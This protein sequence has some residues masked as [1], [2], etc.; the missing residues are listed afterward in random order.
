VEAGVRVRWDAARGQILIAIDEEPAFRVMKPTESFVTPRAM[1]ITYPRLNPLRVEAIVVTEGGPAASGTVAARLR[2]L[3]GLASV[4]TPSPIAVPDGGS[5]TSAPAPCAALAAAQGD[6]RALV[7]ALGAGRAAPT[8]ATQLAT[9]RTAIDDGFAAGGDGPAAVGMATSLMDRVLT[10]V[11]ASTTEVTRI[12]RRLESDASPP[13]AGDAC[14]ASARAVYDTLRLT[15]PRVRLAQLAAVRSAVALLRDALHRDYM[16]TG[17]N[18]WTGDAYRVGADLAPTQASRVTALIRVTH[19]AFDVEPSSGALVGAEEPSQVGVVHAQRFT[20]FAMEF[21]VGTVIGTVTPP[22]YGTT[23]GPSGETVVALV[24]HERTA[25]SAG[26]LASFV[27][28][29]QTGPIVTPMFQVGITTNK[30]VPGLLAGGGIRLFGL[31]KGDVAFGAGWMMAWVKDLR[32]LHVGDPVG[33]TKD[34]AADLGHKRRQGA[35]V[36]FQYKF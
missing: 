35:Y 7:R 23:A 3:I 30:D 8:L 9:W 2:A 14:A 20:R 25:V 13:D 22:H 32:S 15:N 5:G 33:G 27:C 19:F 16:Q 17:P 12:I 10:D 1:R 36:S 31:P 6:A 21:S 29:C 11:D 34:I 28:R 4:V 26:L 18:R 24:S